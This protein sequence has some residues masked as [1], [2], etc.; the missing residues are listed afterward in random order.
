MFLIRNTM[1]VAFGQRSAT[2]AIIKKIYAR[3]EKEINVKPIRILTGSIGPSDQMIVVESVHETLASF[4]AEIEAFNNWPGMAE[5][6][7]QFGSMI[8]P[9]STHFE[10][11]RIQD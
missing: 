1:K 10:A 11:F 2:V 6:G 7:E 5:F 9:G 4:E 8:L 3:A